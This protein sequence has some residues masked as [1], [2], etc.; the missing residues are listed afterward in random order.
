M[1]DAKLLKA[2]AGI[3]GKEHVLGGEVERKL[4]GYDATPFAPLLLPDAVVLPGS[5][6]EI[7]AIVE[8]ANRE[9]F[10]LVPRGAGTNL[11]GGARPV[12]GGVVV[13]TQRLD[14]IVS[15]DA[16]N[17]QVVVQPGVVTAQLQAF[18]EERGLF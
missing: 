16:D 10:P 18:L 5:A 12:R 13:S 15:L 17:L 6:E 1:W 14:R 3:V 4:Y 11:T 8:L 9:R 2:L 7:A